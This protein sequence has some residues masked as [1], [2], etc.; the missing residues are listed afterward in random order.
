MFNEYKML[1]D[2]KL[3]CRKLYYPEIEQIKVS[4]RGKK[5]KVFLGDK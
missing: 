1:S 2:F 5:L 4:G 3:F